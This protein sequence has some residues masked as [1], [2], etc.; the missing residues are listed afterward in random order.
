[1]VTQFGADRSEVSS[2]PATMADTILGPRSAF[3][4][5]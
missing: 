2:S 4:E 3:P 1:M 5:R